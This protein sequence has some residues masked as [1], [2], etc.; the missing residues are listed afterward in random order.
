MG[1]KAGAV[2]DSGTTEECNE[3]GVRNGHPSSHARLI[4]R[5]RS[6]VQYELW[7]SLV[8]PAFDWSSPA[9][10]LLDSA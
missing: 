1:W 10:P 3:I 4:L 6:C 2:K 7:D 9:A 8:D 5:W